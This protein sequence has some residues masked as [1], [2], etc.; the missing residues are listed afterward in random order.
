MDKLEK[1]WEVEVWRSRGLVSVYSCVCEFK[2]VKRN[3]TLLDH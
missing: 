1:T 3:M 2:A